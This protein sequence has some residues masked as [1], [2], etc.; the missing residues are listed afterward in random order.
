[1]AINAIGERRKGEGIKMAKYNVEVA[2]NVEVSIK[3]P[4][5]KPQP[6]S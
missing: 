3:L 1:M 2:Q 6:S 4:S 5:E